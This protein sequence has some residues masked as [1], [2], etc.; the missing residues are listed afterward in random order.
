MLPKKEKRARTW[1]VLRVYGKAAFAY[2]WLLSMAIVAGLVIE[3]AGVT[4]PL[5]MRQFI[6]TISGSTPSSAIAQAL[7]SILVLFALVNLIGWIGQRVRS[8]GVIRLEAKVITDLYQR[9]FDYLLGHSHEFFISNFT[10]TL[11]RRV[12]RYARSF[13]QVFDNLVFNFF[14]AFIF[15]AGVIG[16]LSFRSP[17]L[18]AGLFVWTVSF[19]YVQ[20]RMMQSLQKLRAES[21]AQDSRVTG[22]LSDEVI[23]HST[24]T[25]FAAARYEG[26][27]FQKTIADWYA[28]TRRAWNADAWIYAVQGLFAIGIEIAPLFGAALLWERGL[29][30]VGDFVLIQVYIITLMERL[31]G[32]GQNMRQ[33]YSSFADATEMLDILELPHGIRDILNAKPLPISAGSITFDHVRF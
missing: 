20:F 27:R 7:F 32:I 23:N 4:A 11:T 16:V 19:M 8:V 9:A 30:T 29:V 14:S 25:T 24:I 21:T 10:G 5:Y 13:E 12:T 1:A 22:F 18:G 3:A 28:A 26:L 6:D 31:W 17:L 15:A 33:L 2:P